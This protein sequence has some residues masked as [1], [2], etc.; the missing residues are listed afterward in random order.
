MAHSVQFQP[1][2]GETWADA[3]FADAR[4]FANRAIALA[5]SILHDGS[6]VRGQ[7][8]RAFDPDWEL[9]RTGLT[10]RHPVT[11][12]IADP[13]SGTLD[14]GAIDAALTWAAFIAK[15]T[16]FDTAASLREAARR[17]ERDALRTR[18]GTPWANLAEA[19]A[20]ID[21]LRA[22]DEVR[23]FLKKLTAKT[24]GTIRQG[25]ADLAAEVPEA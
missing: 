19:D 2:E 21:G 16:E 11:I 7:I 23:A 14:P 8:V 5:E 18:A 9:D 22:N 10:H 3:G 25:E 1:P 15:Q 6:I 20:E 13:E 24:W 4:R 17:V 12:Q